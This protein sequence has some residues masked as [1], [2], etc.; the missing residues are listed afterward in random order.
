MQKLVKINDKEEAKTYQA[1]DKDSQLTIFLEKRIEVLKKTKDNILD[2]FN[3]LELMKRAD[4]EYKPKD[5]LETSSV[6]SLVTVA[7]E[8]S[9]SDSS[10]ATIVDVSLAADKANWRSSISEPTLL[11]KIQTALS[12]LIDQN[13]EAVFNTDIEKYQKRNNIG[14][15]LWKRNWEITA[16]KFLS[17]LYLTLLS[18]D[19]QL[20]IQ[21]LVY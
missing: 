1:D 14:K 12:I 17:Y 11:V 18:M 13:P 8:E 4:R 19:L 20:D 16:L 9:G 3:F 5:L 6:A 10:N 15:A 7:D 21:F 2:G